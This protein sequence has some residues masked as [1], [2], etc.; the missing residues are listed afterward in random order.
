MNP[1]EIVE[2][3]SY[4]FLPP[5]YQHCYNKIMEPNNP[6]YPFFYP[7]GIVVI[8]VSRDPTKLGYGLARNLIMSGYPGA[9]HFVNPRGGTLF[10]HPIYPDISQI[11]DPVD[12]ALVFAPPP[13]VPD[14]LDAC[15][16]RGIKAAVILTGGFRETG[17]DG[18]ALEEHCLEIARKYSIR[19]I[20]PNCVGLV[21]AHLPADT[22]FLQP[23]PPPS[24]DIAFISHSGAIIAAIV[25]WMRGQGMGVSHLLSL[26]NQTDVTETDTLLPV[27]EDNKTK[28][29]TLYLESNRDGLRFIEVA[30]KASRQKPIIALKV[31]RFESGRRA[32]ASHT[33]AMAGSEQALQAAFRR[34]G[35][36]R[37]ETT[38]EMFQWAR[39]L[40]WSP[41]LPG[42]RIA[43]LTNAGGPGV[44]ASD[45]LEGNGLQL[46]ILENRTIDELKTFL[47]LAG[48][49][50]NPVDMLASATPEQYARSLQILLS[51]PGVD[52]VMVITP[53]PPMHSTGQVAKAII[54][55]IQTYQKPVIVVLM[56]DTLIQ[57]AVQHLRAA[58]IPEFRFPEEAASA[59]CALNQRRK[60]LDEI[61]LPFL[62]EPGHDAIKARSIL[63]SS[64]PG[65]FLPVD[66]A[67]DLANCY[68]IPT[69]SAKMAKSSDQAVDI[70]IHCGFP[71]ALK[72]LSPD[73]PHKSDVGGV[74]LDIQ[75]TYQVKEAYQRIIENVSTKIPTANIEGVQIQ[76][77]IPPGQDVIVGV[78]R[79]PQFGP[80]VMFGSGGIEVEGLKDVAF[81]LAPLTQ[82]DLDRLLQSTWAGKK[83]SGF[84]N[85]PAAD[86]EAVRSILIRLGDLATNHPEINEFEINPLRVLTPGSG[87]V[88]LDIR[89]KLVDKPQKEERV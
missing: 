34:A 79:D 65:M 22:T 80:L 9:V 40:A 29:I 43:V 55:V 5:S 18:A 57:E 58:H 38:V 20:G 51:D 4:I 83:L 74:I 59:F 77:M 39:T 15:G 53:P 33:G 41:A 35:V 24:G 13:A 69:A 6:L 28:V 31:G 54:P 56:G 37:A 73:I 2:S 10:D 3:L 25:D 85:I 88:G 49:F 32:A 71:I 48:S 89:V 68:G 61:N 52:G 14:T 45:A 19:L 75:D 27:A 82:A 81:S 70:A 50:I 16:K 66:Q 46:A 67:V 1:P 12:L 64:F 60:I 42:K 26:G 30:K 36:I 72:I 78:I 23:P 17:S 76:K 84:R 87:A 21:H 7:Q 44:T 63:S 47:P 8:G 62:S 86:Q 11:P